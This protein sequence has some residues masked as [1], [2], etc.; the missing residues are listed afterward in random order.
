MSLL[1][2]KTILVT[3]GAGF[4]GSALICELNNRGFD[5]ILVVDQLSND[6]KFKNLISLRFED[7]FEA[8]DFLNMVEKRDEKLESISHIFHLGACSSTTENNASYLI[9]NNFEYTKTIAHFAEEKKRRFVYASSA[10]TYGDGSNGMSDIPYPNFAIRPLNAYGF[11]KHIFDIYAARH[12]LHCYG[13]KYFN[14][15][16][17]NEYHKGSMRSMVLKAY[18]SIY[19]TGRVGLFKSNKKEYRHG[20]QKRDFLYV[21]DAVNMTIFLAEVPEVVNGQPTFGIYNLGSGVASTWKELVTPIFQAMNIEVNIDFIDMPV[22]LRNKYQYY[23]CADISKL[24]NVGYDKS[25]TPLKN[26]VLDYVC[27]FLIPG[28]KYLVPEKI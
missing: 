14:V 24:R 13:M 25:I 22:E 4:I 23:T 9:K 3:G 8:D 2:S 5:N 11:S 1:D 17:P 27:N 19:L 21:K 15:F 7:Y 28:E 12:D 10:A 20:E 16:G 26:A 6:D 18:E